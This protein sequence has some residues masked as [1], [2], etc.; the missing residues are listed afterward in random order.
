[1]AERAAVGLGRVRDGKGRAEGAGRMRAR[2]YATRGSRSQGW[3]AASMCVY[4][5]AGEVC[6][7]CGACA[8]AQAVAGHDGMPAARQAV[9]APFRALHHGEFLGAAGCWEAA[10]NKWHAA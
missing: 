8:S 3:C 9:R 1:M 5:F 10:G 6:V 2:R 7:A 4:G